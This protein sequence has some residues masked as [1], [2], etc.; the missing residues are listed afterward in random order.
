[1]TDTM[2]SQ[3]IDFSSRDTLCQVVTWK[4]H[5]MKMR[6]LGETSGCTTCKAFTADET[7]ASIWVP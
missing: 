1:M 7:K 4:R 2:T 5:T 3:N 6:R